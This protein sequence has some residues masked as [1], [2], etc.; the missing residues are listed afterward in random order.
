MRH[1]NLAVAVA[2]ALIGL[3]AV[4]LAVPA[5]ASADVISNF[6]TNLEGWT[7]A[8]NDPFS[9]FTY[10]ASS[11]NPGGY[12]LFGDGAQGKW[13]DFSAPAKFLGNDSEYVN[14]S[15]NFDL[16]HNEPANGVANNPLCITDTSGDWISVV[17]AP[18]PIN[19]WTSYSFALNTSSGFLFDGGAA[20]TQSQIDTVLSDVASIWV[21]AD[22]YGGP[23][24]TGLDNVSLVGAPE[25]GTLTLL[26]SALL[27]LAGAFYL[28]RRGAK[29]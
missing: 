7:L 5:T 12:A 8:N 22:L 18:L 29:A 23:D 3:I 17:I 6:D 11:G 19:E 15:F 14:G 25:P 4:A 2:L 26:C 20:A 27:G 9:T 21:P 28:R 13:D 10:Q 16:Y 24:D 1:F